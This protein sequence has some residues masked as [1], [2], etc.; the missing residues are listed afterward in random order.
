LAGVIL[1]DTVLK[2]LS[3]FFLSLPKE[4]SGVGGCVELRLVFGY[5]RLAGSRVNVIET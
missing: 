4:N 3:A 2:N 1:L 5:K